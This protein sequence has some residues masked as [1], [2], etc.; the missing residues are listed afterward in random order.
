VSPGRIAPGQDRFEEHHS[1]GVSV[2]DFKLS[3][4]TRMA[5]S[6]SSRMCSKKGGPA[7]H[8]HYDQDEWFYALEGESVLKSDRNV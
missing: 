2:L 8:L 5:A 4:G 7:R 6:L 3:T 1:L